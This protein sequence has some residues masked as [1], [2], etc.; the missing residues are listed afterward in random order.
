[1]KTLTLIF[2]LT[3]FQLALQA[4]E[5]NNAMSN[6]EQFCK[7]PGRKITGYLIYKDT[8]GFGNSGI[9]ALAM[10]YVDAASKETMLGITFSGYTNNTT[11]DCS[12]YKYYE[13]VV[14]Y[15][16]L[17]KVISWLESNKWIA[18]S[19]DSTIGFFS[20]AP[21]KGN[22]LLKLKRRMT[23]K[24]SAYLSNYWDFTIQFNKNDI[25][26]E[27]SF[28]IESATVINKLKEI[29]RMIGNK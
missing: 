12:F 29:Q 2:G 4:Q 6:V 14:D 26:S 27:K 16:E 10:K 11:G 22:Y 7:A 1:M 3:L 8:Y 28:F 21:Q 19:S 9:T 18:N 23:R 15:D 20:Y 25:D 13:A 5:M 17:S 24:G